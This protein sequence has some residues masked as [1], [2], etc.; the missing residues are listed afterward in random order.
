MPFCTLLTPHTVIV[1]ATGVKQQQHYGTAELGC[2]P[3]ITYR[4]L[5]KLGLGSS[6]MTPTSDP[7]PSSSIKPKCGSSLC[8][9]AMSAA[10]ARSRQQ[11][12]DEAEPS[13]DPLTTDL[14]SP[15]MPGSSSR[16]QPDAGSADSWGGA[17]NPQGVPLSVLQKESADF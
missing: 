1:Q 15:Q 12:Q 5:Q 17:D 14:S 2:Q 4:L 10:E 6:K 3:L 7:S 13:S 9:A 16:R 11:Q 8:N